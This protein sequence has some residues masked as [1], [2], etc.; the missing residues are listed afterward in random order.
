M[1]TTMAR[2]FLKTRL[3]WIAL[4][5]LLLLGVFTAAAAEEG[6]PR[7]GGTLVFGLEKDVSTLNPFVRMQS[8]DMDVRTHVYEALLDSDINGNIISAL[9]ESWEISKDGVEYTFK[10]RRGVKFHNG[11]DMTA[12][13]V[14]WSANYAMNPKVGATGGT[15]A[16][17]VKSVAALDRSTIR[18][19]LKVPQ[20]SFLARMATL[21]PFPVVPKDAIPESAEKFS[22]YPP[23]TGPFVFKEWK[24][25]R[26][27]VL[28]RFRDYWQKGVPYLD[29][30]VF[31]PVS[32][33]SVRFASLRAGD[34]HMIE[35]TPYQFVKKVTTGEAGQVRAVPARISGFDRLAFNVVEPPFNNPKLRLAVAYAI[36]KKR[37]IEGVY[38]GYGE[39]TDQRGFPGSPWFVKL[40][41]IERDTAKMKALLR[42]A[43]VGENFEFEI[44]GRKGDDDAYQVLQNQL[45]TAGLKA[46]VVVVSSSAYQQ[47]TRA[48]EFQAVVLGGS[49]APDPDDIYT[50]EYACEGE[51]VKTKKRRLNY[52]GYCNPEVDRLL[53]EAGRIT[54]QKKRYELYSKVARIL[55]EEMPV[56]N[57]ALVPRFFTLSEKVKGF[58]TDAAGRF[59]TTTFGISRVWLD[60]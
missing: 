44:L 45:T 8:T 3:A 39:P 4:A 21:R 13:D 34:L 9:A 22:T 27:V 50:P 11:R 57:L 20:A 26:Q 28:T 6:K 47:R 32:D 5:G 41:P 56:V 10:L 46:K 31:R 12:E 37:Y 60:K 7:H 51:A 58:R 14:L 40:P 54:D 52:P 23:G 16:E 43:G 17:N 15:Q 53:A 33:P 1:Q 24:P 29:E 38:W 35:R 42:E 36:D 59:S 25:E 30:I 55:N 49:L 48:G 18:F 2:S 19:T